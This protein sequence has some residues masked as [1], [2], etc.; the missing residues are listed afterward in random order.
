MISEDPLLTPQSPYVVSLS[1]DD[2]TIGPEWWVFSL[3]LPWEACTWGELAYSP[4]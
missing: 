3:T 4:R 1:T 2:V